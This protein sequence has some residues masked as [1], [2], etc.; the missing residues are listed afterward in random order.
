MRAPSVPARVAGIAAAEFDLLN[1]RADEMRA[2]GRHVISLGQAL[3]P[4]GPPA[5]ALDA[6]REA[7][8][9][10][11][12]HV[13]S[14]DAGLPSLREAIGERVGVA[15]DEIIVTAGANQA[16]MLALMTLVDP[17]DEVLLPAPYFVNHDMAVRAIGAVPV[18]VPLDASRGF[19]LEW[20]RVEPFVTDRTRAVVVCTPSNP[21]GAVAGAQELARIARE[22]ASRGILLLADQTYDRFVYDA[23]FAS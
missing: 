7:L 17:G 4:F 20:P 3:P 15:A 8:A 12:A 9:N 18:E 1:A 14:A 6:A 13:Y 21:T 19:P 10:P 5:S 16:F 11:D 2:G 23:E 22:L